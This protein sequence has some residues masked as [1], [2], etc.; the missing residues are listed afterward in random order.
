ML[1]GLIYVFGVV[2]DLSCVLEF[3][4]VSLVL[5]MFGWC[6]VGMVCGD[7]VVVDCFF[8]LFFCI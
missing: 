6:N 8:N 4:V 3:D 5:I 2:D 7:C 1:E